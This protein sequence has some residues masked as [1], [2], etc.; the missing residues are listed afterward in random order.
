MK[1][2][3]TAD[4]LLMIS[5]MQHY[6]FCKRQ[7]ALIHQEQMWSEN[8]FTVKGEILHEK[9]DDP[10]LVE[11]RKNYFISRSMPLVSYEMG[12]Y[13]VSDAVEFHKDSSG[14]KVHSREGLYKIIPIEYKV[15]KP[16]EDHRD[17]VQLCVQ[18][19]CLEEMF[20]THIEEAYLYYGKTRRRTAVEIN[21]TL[22][23]EVWDLA[24]EM[25]ESFDGDLKI[26]GIYSD[27]CD[28]C[29]LYDACIPKIKGGYKSV[30]NYI[31]IT[32]DRT[33]EE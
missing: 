12:F 22:R 8:V 9:V 10:F 21:E 2:I 28:N 14:C 23:K 32:L 33:G 5:G 29:S 4:D 31:R 1:A 15:G 6:F 20:K 24:E 3:Y 13:G 7:W 17:M 18:A 26:Q 30:E 27:K 16:K 11:T 19:I 25:H